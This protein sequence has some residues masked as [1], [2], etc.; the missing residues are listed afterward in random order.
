MCWVQL[1]GRRINV[2]KTE[3]EEEKCCLFRKFQ[4]EFPLLS[5]DG[6]EEDSDGKKRVTSEN[7]AGW[8]GSTLLIE[9]EC[10]PERDPNIEWWKEG[11]WR[12]WDSD[13][14]SW[15]L[16]ALWTPTLREALWLYASQRDT[17]CHCHPDQGSLCAKITC[18]PPASLA[19]DQ[20]V[21][22]SPF[23][24][25]LCGSVF[26]MISRLINGQISRLMALL[27]WWITLL[28]RTVTYRLQHYGLF[29][30]QSN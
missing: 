9:I 5:R 29:P 18:I 20:T 8:S 15:F 17:A 21:P 6:R 23:L 14:M 10:T 26:S 2:N 3:R 28:S 16:S 13:V 24:F 11:K 27:E 12:C 7:E 4:F 25:R 19:I 22:I 1:K 30:F